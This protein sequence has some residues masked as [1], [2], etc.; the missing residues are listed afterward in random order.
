M[1]RHLVGAAAGIV[2]AGLLAGGFAAVGAGQQ[3]GRRLALVVGNN[4][5]PAS[6]LSACRNDARAMARALGE[7]GFAVTLLED[8]TFQKLADTMGTMAGA[9]RPEDVVFFYFS[10]HGSQAEGE[11][12]LIPIDYRGDTVE[13]LRLGTISAGLVQ[14]LFQ[15]ARVTVLVLDACR[16]NPYARDR[17]GGRGLASMEARGSLIAFATGADQVALDGTSEGNGVFTEALL[18]TMRKPGLTVQEVFRQARQKV[19]AAT[20]GKQFPAVY[21]GLIGDLILRPGGAA[22]APTQTIPGGTDLARRAELALW[23]SIKDL[24]DPRVFEDYLDKYPDGKF[25]VAAEA[26]LA[27]L[28]G[29]AEPPRPSPTSP[30]LG[31]VPAEEISLDGPFTLLL[32][33]KPAISDQKFLQFADLETMKGYFQDDPYWKKGEYSITSVAA[34]NNG[35]LVVLSKLGNDAQAY[36]YGEEFPKD[37]VKKRWDEGYRITEVGVIPGRWFV[38]LS[39]NSGYGGQYYWINE[40]WPAD[41]IKKQWDAGQRITQAR[42]RDGKYVV[43]TSECQGRKIGMQRWKKGWDDAWVKEARDKGLVISLVVP[44]KDEVYYVMSEFE[45]EYDGFRLTDEKRFPAADLAKKL[46]E[47]YWVTFLY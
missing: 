27:E 11:N 34:G 10:G 15:R 28:R 21:D 40:T 26:R 4:A 39:K 3:G 19:Y 42:W 12:F 32:E 38:V 16:T 41:F 8:A 37:D 45:G 47:G 24:K 20:N 29:A 23:E 31:P 5:Y 36:V 22:P 17:A 33:K 35:I 6:P 43:V 7:V 18:E 44:G 9:V 2:L 30:A 46:A 13:A 14:K 25:R 1:R